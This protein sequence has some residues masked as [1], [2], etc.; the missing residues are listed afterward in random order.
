MATLMDILRDQQVSF[1]EQIDLPS[2]EAKYLP[3]PNALDERVRQQ[4]N[5]LYPQGMYAHQSIALERLLEGK[6]VCLETSTSSGKSAVFNAFAAHHVMKNP[7]QRVLALY[8]MKALINDQLT[9]WIEFTKGLGLKVGRIDGSVTGDQ[10]EAILRESDVLLMTPDVA[11]AWLLGKSNENEKELKSFSLVVIDEAHAYSGVFGSNMAYL[12]RRLAVLLPSMQLITATA[13]ISNSRKFIQDLTGREPLVVG[14]DQEGQPSPAK[15]VYLVDSE[16][17]MTTDGMA[18]LVHA[19]ARSFDGKFI[20]FVDSRKSAEMVAARAHQIDRRGKSRLKADDD[21]MDMH[22][23]DDEDNRF[24]GENTDADEL[25]HDGSEASTAEIN[26]SSVDGLDQ[27]AIE[28]IVVTYR[29]GY[30]REDQEAIQEALTSGTLRGVVSTSALELGVDIGEIDLVVLLNTPPS[31]KSFWQR[32][33]RAGR[34]GKLGE[35]LIFDTSTTIKSMGLEG[36]LAQD[37]EPNYLYLDNRYI[38]YTNALCASVEAPEPKSVLK[39]W[40]SASNVP[41]AFLSMLANEIDENDRVDDDLFALKQK[42]EGGYHLMFSM[43][44]GAEDQFALIT[45][46]HSP[47]L[48]T[49]PWSQVLREAYPGGIYYHRSRPYLV[50]YINHKN[51][52]I[53]VQRTA[54]YM[55]TPKRVARVFPNFMSASEYL[56]SDLG[57]VIECD[58]QVS[59]RVTGCSVQKGSARSE[60]VYGQGS[61]PRQR[62]LSRFVRSTGVLWQFHGLHEGAEEAARLILDRYSEDAQVHASDVAVGRFSSKNS[63]SGSGECSGICIYDAVDGGL[64]LTH[65]LYARFEDIIERAILFNAGTVTQE[66]MSALHTMLAGIRACKVISIS[67]GGNIVSTQDDEWVTVVARGELAMYVN[68][69]NSDEVR[70]EDWNYTKNGIMYRFAVPGTDAKKSVIA[71]YIMPLSGTTR[72]VRYN[73]DTGETEEGGIAP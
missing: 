58:V 51:G 59:E 37:S 19:L 44:S 36:Y 47:R 67:S 57:F 39:K 31:M 65:E 1:A 13:T 34:R 26:E 41:A 5:T 4:L 16:S 28:N 35:C 49:M 72:V 38:Q 69:S 50:K 43:R 68:G 63:P 60:I 12:M 33:G 27:L 6:D 40:Q 11:H 61:F 45:N 53:T 2:R 42:G 54:P 24:E 17:R 64:K 3:V 73:A 23:D 71:P 8:P 18:Q 7:G 20:A 14:K 46:S 62:A 9:K 25:T 15:R 55:S 70:I 56:V 30:E 48:G 66:V 52:E 22:D 21:I 32:F 29:A 10:R